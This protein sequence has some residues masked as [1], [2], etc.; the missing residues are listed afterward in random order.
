METVTIPREEYEILKGL[1]AK[2]EQ[3]E[4]VIHEPINDIIKR[5]IKEINA[6]PSMGKNEKEL[7]EYLKKRGVK[8]E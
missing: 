5:R 6:N 8:V 7:N 4:E 3:I 2:M 1:A